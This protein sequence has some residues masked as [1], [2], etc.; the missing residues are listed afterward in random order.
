MATKGQASQRSTAHARQTQ[1]DRSA[2]TRSR[3]LEAVVACIEEEGFARTTSQR[4]ARRAGVSVGAVQH[5][6]LSKADILR[7]VLEESFGELTTAFEGAS[8]AGATVEE[9]VAEFVERAW[10]H[11][12]SRRFRSTLEIIIG[13]RDSLSAPGSDWAAAPLAESRA[14][15]QTL[16]DSIFVGLDVPVARQ[17]DLLRFAFVN[18]AGIAMT[19]RFEPSEAQAQRQL[20]LLEAAMISLLRESS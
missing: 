19:A 15:A 17:R 5:H 11:Y 13:T 12:G 8:L 7:A 4:I 6:F 10:R 18:L 1:A 16:W 3:I 9:R 20:G 2:A 14:R